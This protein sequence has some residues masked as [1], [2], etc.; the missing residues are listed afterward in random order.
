MRKLII[1]PGATQALGGTLVTLSLLIKGIIKQGLGDSLCVLTRTGSLMENYL[2]EADQQDYLQLIEANSDREFI[3]KSLDWVAHQPT[4]WPLLLDNCIARELLP[5]LTKSA[6]KLRF[7]KRSVYFFFH[8]LG[9]SYNP[10][11]YISRKL[12]FLCLNPTGLCNSHFTAEHIQ[13]F[14][15]NVSAILYQPV[16]IDKFKPLSQP[17]LQA[18]TPEALR[19]I[20]NSGAQI[21]LTPSRLNKPGIVNDKNLRALIPVLAELTR[22]GFNYHSVVIGKDTSAD[23]SHTKELHDLAA[24]FDV[25]DKFTILP[26]VFNI[27]SYYP[28]ANVMLSLAPREPFG[29]TVVEAI[30]CGIPV[31]GSSTGGIG[32][33]LNHFAPEWTVAPENT[34]ATAD[35]ILAVADNPNTSNRVSQGQRWVKER[36]SIEAYTRQ[37]LAASGLQPESK[38]NQLESLTA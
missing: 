17:E 28:H 20:L 10:M 3:E 21:I 27:E 36:C 31:V 30:A 35:A 13:R 23:K 6:L 18:H 32:E 5:T 22:R 29:R 2:I 7:S 8:D 19:P 4:N 26:P 38:L 9:L 34:V 15:N 12:M 11:G 25:A 14:V 1:L 24:E 37:I 16:D 33:I